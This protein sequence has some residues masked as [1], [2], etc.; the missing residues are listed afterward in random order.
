MTD[1]MAR[2]MFGRLRLIPDEDK[3]VGRG[4]GRIMPCFLILDQESSGSR[5]SNNEFGAYYAAHELITAIKESIF[6]RE[7]FLAQTLEPAQ[8]VDNIV[9]LANIKGTMHDI[10]GKQSSYPE[11]YKD[12]NYTQSQAFAKKVK[13]S[14]AL[15]IV[16]DSVR[17]PQGQCVAVFRPGCI[18]HCRDSYIIT[19]IWNG[20][21][22]TGHYK[23]GN[24]VRE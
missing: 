14:G 16:Y 9:I 12:N 15:G 6:R 13:E 1:D 18:S 24:F 19:Y 4:A 20:K 8:E 7:K 22:I 5:F 17:Y 11:L 3:M 10:R 21:K 23:K 2:Q